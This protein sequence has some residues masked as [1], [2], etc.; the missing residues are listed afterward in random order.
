MVDE[1]RAISKQTYYNINTQPKDTTMEFQLSHS[2]YND[3]NNTSNISHFLSGDS[4][5]ALDTITPRTMISVFGPG[6]DRFSDQDKGYTDPEWYFRGPGG[7]ILGIGFRWG[8][9]R[10]RGKNLQS[11]FVTPEDICTKFI[12]QL[13][14]SIDDFAFDSEEEANNA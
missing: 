10:V 8:T 6:D 14:T 12:K 4:R 3:S 7:T 9:P 5:T 11:Q 1:T 2:Y 13:M